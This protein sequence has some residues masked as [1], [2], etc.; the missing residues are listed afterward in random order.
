MPLV[1]M[2]T[3]VPGNPSSATNMFDPPAST[4]SGVLAVSVSAIAVMSWSSVEATIQ[5]VAGP[6]T[7]AVVWFASKFSGMTL[8][9]HHCSGSSQYSSVVVIGVSHHEINAHDVGIFIN[10]SDSCRDFQLCPW[11]WIIERLSRVGTMS[12]LFNR[13]HRRKPS[14]V[15]DDRRWIISPLCY[16]VHSQSHTEHAVG[17]HPG[18]FVLLCGR[19]RPVYGVKVLRSSG[20]SDEVCTI[21]VD[22]S[23]GDDFAFAKLFDSRHENTPYPRT[24]SVEITVATGARLALEISV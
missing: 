23:G 21:N 9:L 24:S 13:N 4:S 7:R 6:P 8:K 11:V 18:Q 15:I 22:S 12:G 10:I 3:T 16:H 20:I 19:N 1:A 14:L 17:D 5:V 2:R